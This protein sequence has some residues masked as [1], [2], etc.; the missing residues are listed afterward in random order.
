MNKY[1]KN[2]GLLILFLVFGMLFS[3]CIDNENRS[4]YSDSKAEYLIKQGAINVD[5]N[6]SDWDSISS[7]EVNKKK[8]LWIGEGLQKGNWKGDS[9][10]KYID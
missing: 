6:I 1:I 4:G 8:N 3:N 9:V 2:N 5:G 10:D 7:I